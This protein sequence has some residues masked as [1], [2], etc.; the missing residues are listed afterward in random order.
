MPGTKHSKKD[1][2]K[3]ANK[4]GKGGKHQGESSNKKGKGDKDQGESSMTKKNVKVVI[5][6]KGPNPDSCNNIVIGIRKKLDDAWEALLK[7]KESEW[8]YLQDTNQK[9]QKD[10]EI[11]NLEAVILENTEEISKWTAA[12]PSDGPSSIIRTCDY[13][14]GMLD[15]LST[16]Y[17]NH[18]AVSSAQNELETYRAVFEE[19]SKRV[20]EN[21][22][23]IEWKP[24]KKEDK[25]K[26]ASLCVTR[27]ES[28]F[29]M[30]HKNADLTSG[31]QICGWK[32]DWNQAYS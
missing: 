26:F 19:L 28:P 27:G 8:D 30:L 9:Q 21:E 1:S 20:S 14:R 2:S 29:G 12:G 32:V 22:W 17:S 25:T 15:R 5:K 13:G 18:P 24:Y 6:A 16:G 31:L 10:I 7:D 4:H 23:E 11:K 3:S